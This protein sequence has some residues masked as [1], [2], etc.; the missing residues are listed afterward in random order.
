VDVIMQND[1][2]SNAEPCSE[3]MQSPGRRIASFYES[4]DEEKQ[5]LSKSQRTESVAPIDLL[6]A[7]SSSSFHEDTTTR[8]AAIIDESRN[9]NTNPRGGDVYAAN[10]FMQTYVLSVRVVLSTLRNPLATYAQLGQ[11]LFMALLV[12]LSAVADKRLLVNLGVH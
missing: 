7:Y 9:I 3:Y 11:V 5:I 4:G 10:W 12:C 6:T 1:L 8:I 2:Q